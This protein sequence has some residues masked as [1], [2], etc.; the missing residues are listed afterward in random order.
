MQF[1]R[2]RV[3]RTHGPLYLALADAIGGAIA[4]GELT[5]GMRL[6]PQR[7]LAKLLE[8]DPT[9]VTRGYA[10]ARRRGLVD[11]T[12]GRGTFVL[13]GQAAAARPAALVDLS[14][15]MPPLP[16]SPS[17]RQMLQDGLA[18]LMRGA[19][20]H[21]LMTYHL[22]AGSPAD[23]E[24]GAA[25]LRPLLGEVDPGRVLVCSGAQCA[26]SA[27]ISLLSRPGDVMLTEPLTYPRFRSAAAQGGV[28]LHAVAADAEGLLPDA[29]AAACRALRPKALYCVPTLQ[30]PTTVT[31]PQARRCAVAEVARRHGVT[32]IEDDAYGALPSVPVRALA[33]FAPELTFYVG[34]L[35]KCLSPGLRIAYVAAPPAAAAR[36]E[37]VLRATSMM[38]PP[39]MAALVTLWVRQGTAAALREGVRREIAARQSI[40]RAMLPEGSFAAGESGPHLWLTLPP[41]WHRIAFGAHVRALGLAVAVADAFAVGE[42]TPNAVRIGLGAAS[43]QSA[44]RTA[45][46]AVS[47]ALRAEAPLGAGE[48]V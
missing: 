45:L 29:L 22:G 5:Q 11:A 48:V 27:L 6:P 44:L 43:G 36:L 7:A 41:A 13:G 32:V 28:R 10:E 19:D 9:T 31:M 46:A 2:P 25:W 21:A 12:V 20:L 47:A 40:A 37:A 18:A 26:L 34:T 38:P 4:A 17:L 42:T 35:A 15:N 14:M 16:A 23:R 8:M 39:L 1:W 30:N 24:A 33:T 3:D